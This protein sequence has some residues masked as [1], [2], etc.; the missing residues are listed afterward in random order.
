M[1]YGI[2]RPQPLVQVD[3]HV[4]H[5]AQCA[6]GW[7]CDEVREIVHT[8]EVL[9]NRLDKLVLV[10]FQD[11]ALLLQLKHAPFGSERVGGVGR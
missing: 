8:A 1:V 2:H 11:R 5:V 9:R 3:Q 6:V 7:R 4:D 10:I